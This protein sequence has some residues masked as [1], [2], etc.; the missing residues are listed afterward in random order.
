MNPS[1]PPGWFFFVMML[2][3]STVGLAG[4][5]G[6]GM[7]SRGLEAGS[8]RASRSKDRPSPTRSSVRR[9]WV[10][11]RSPFN[12]GSGATNEALRLPDGTFAGST[13]SRSRS[14]SSD[15][16][17]S[18]GDL[19]MTLDEIAYGML[20]VHLRANGKQ[21]TKEKAILAAFPTVTSKGGGQWQRASHIYDTIASA[22][23]LAITRASQPASTATE[24][25]DKQ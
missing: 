18:P 19:T 15:S 10:R 12:A 7:A 14:D 24:G 17:A 13:G 11:T 5:I 2:I 3:C 1:S 8:A 16:S 25:S 22:D 6:L 21:P 9:S 20:A 4:I 23:K